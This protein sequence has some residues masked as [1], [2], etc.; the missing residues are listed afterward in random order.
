LKK[1]GASDVVIFS[2]NQTVLFEKGDDEQVL[3]KLKIMGYPEADTEA[4]NSKMKKA[5]S[6]AFC[7]V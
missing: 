6:Y 7:A 4:A 5:Q 3:K 1:L 2:E